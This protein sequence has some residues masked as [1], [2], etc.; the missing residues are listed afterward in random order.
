MNGLVIFL[1]KVTLIHTRPIGNNLVTKY[2]YSEGYYV[3][4]KIGIH[5]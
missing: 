2:R 5:V 3:V 1:E 4:K